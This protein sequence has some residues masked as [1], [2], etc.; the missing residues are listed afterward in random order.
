M[1]EI[2]NKISTYQKLD[3]SE[4]MVFNRLKSVS[5]AVGIFSHSASGFMPV[6]DYKLRFRLD[7]NT[8]K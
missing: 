4:Y 7:W 8:I 6:S 2:R 3:T 1:I 5:I